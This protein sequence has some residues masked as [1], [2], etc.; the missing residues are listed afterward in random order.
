MINLL[1]SIIVFCI[2]GG[3]LYYLV[4]LLPLPEPF[5]NIIRIC[6]VLIAILLLLGLIFG[7][8]SMPFHIRG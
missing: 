3:L 7:G 2:V 8:V 1:I 4:S 5:P 6:V